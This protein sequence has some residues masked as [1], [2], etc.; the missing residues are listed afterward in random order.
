MR[1]TLAGRQTDRK[2]TFL[3]NHLIQ[4]INMQKFIIS[5][6]GGCLLTQ[7]TTAQNLAGFAYGTPSAPTGQEWQSPEQLSLNKE[8]PHAWFFSFADVQTAR[9][10][11]PE[12]SAYWQ[13]LDGE[14][15][16]HWAPNPS[17]RP[18]DFYKPAFDVSG[19][20]KVEVPM[21]WNVAG[22]QKDGT[23]KYGTP[24]YSNQRVIFK[25]TVAVDDWKGGV[26]REPPKDWPTYKDRNEVGSY[27]RTFTV[28]ESWNGR[29]VYV[30]FDG[31]DSFFYLYI[32]GHYVGFSKNS[33][34]TASF[35]ITPYLVKGENV[36]AAEVYRS[37]DASFLESQDMFRLPGI[38]R[39]VALTSTPKVQ[40]RDVRAIPD[41]DATYTNGLL[42]IATDI[43][44]LDKKTAKNY[45]LT[46]SLY[47]NRLYSDE[48]TPVMNAMKSVPV[49]TLL[50][51]ASTTVTT[52]LQA[53]EVKKWSAEAPY[54][55]TLVGELKNEK[56][57]T[58]ETF[59]TIVG[60][61]KVE[62][63]DTPA[64]QDEFGLAG[65]YFYI[66][67]KTVKLK[68]VN[69]HET[70]PERG[71][72]ITRQQM[73]QEVMLMKRANINHVRNSHYSDDPYWYYLCN[74]YGIY[75]EDEA[76]L[77]SH[78]Y[79][80][81]K[82]SLSHPVEWKAAH[83]ARNA[84]MVHANINNPSIVIWS[85]GNEAGPGKNFNAA[86]DAI[87]KI[88]RSRPVQYERNNDIVDMGSN[89][90]P[91]IAWVKG[92]VTGK[93]DIKYPFH[94]SEY[95]H[96]M[97]NATGNLIDYWNAIES[98][99]YFMG[100][101]IWEWVDHG[102]YN[103][104]ANTGTRYL[105]YGGDF[106][107]KPNDGM[108]CMDG[109]MLPDLTP[110][111]QYYEVKKVYQNVGITPVDMKEGKI[112]IF[113]KNYFE[114]FRDYDFTWSLYKDGV[115]IDGGANLIGPR[116]ALGPREKM[117]YTIPYK[118][119]LLEPGSEYF[120]KVQLTL[121]RDLPWAKIGYP[122]MEEQ[123]LVKAAQQAPAITTVA[124]GNKLKIT[125]AGD[126]SVISGKNFTAKFD[127]R[128]G[129]IYSL[130]YNGQ[131]TI[132]EGKGPKL[133]AFRAP[134]DNDNWAMQKWVANGLHNLRHKVIRSSYTL[135]K[136]GTVLLSYTVESQAPNSATL[137]GGTSGHYTVTEH[138]DK[139]FGANDFRF[140]T[141]QNWIIYKDGSIELAS[142][143]TSNNP[144][145]DLARIG[146]TLEMPSAYKDYTYY[147]RGPVNNYNDRKTG[148]FI[149][150]HKAPVAEQGIM[151]SK[152]QAQGNRE[153]VRWCAVTDA[154]G[155]GL[156]FIAS[157]PMSASAL[158]WSQQE[159]MF[160][161]HPYQLPKSSGTHLHLDA[162]VTGLGGNSCGQ[163]APLEYDRTR[164]TARHFSFL[165]RP[166]SG[167]NEQAQADVSL[168][169]E[170]P[171]L[172]ERDRA[173]K[174]TIT[175]NR[176]GIYY[177]IG[178]GRKQLYKKPFTLT[179][180][181]QVKAWYLSAP[182]LKYTNAFGRIESIPTTVVYASSQEPDE[183]DATQLTDGDP[184]T[185]WHT[186]YSVTLAKFPHWVDFD[187]GTVKLLKGFTYLPRQDSRNGNIKNYRVQV[188]LD[189]KTWGAPVAEGSFANDL[190][191]KKV[192]FK[193]PV[194]AR[195]LRFTALIEQS[196][197][198]YASGAEFTVLAQ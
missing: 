20:A 64:A 85:L 163:G 195:Y 19:W 161:P 39:T 80:Y 173:G 138:T 69:R 151:L 137:N 118:Y 170:E 152:P 133:D 147:G 37:S 176:H 120:V 172:I 131:E 145:L 125:T 43:R 154:A 55:Y 155:N 54:R 25:H 93:Y 171:L 103:Y 116:M 159:L 102:L 197:Q 53:G 97:G 42:N 185:Y 180:S 178:N 86:Y 150:L 110:K 35:D 13:S 194:K 140:T 101:A 11:L 2:G 83:V 89:Q 31:V 156:S 136:D 91:S 57:K 65:R 22:I 5:F 148:Q 59:S 144:A 149:E 198:D 71:H 4:T 82:A 121:K 126:Y 111:G 175:G 166:V 50:K 29:E 66:N 21:C 3:K 74:K 73:E 165:I 41:L 45:T 12:A 130:T 1:L 193:Q 7:L 186:M 192:L 62:I 67:G 104:D 27:R 61:R 100:G 47:A 28:P 106:N 162:M 117:V 36:I 168:A 33:R 107:D 187:A 98:T 15:R 124:K 95:G 30:N 81:G 129:T 88:D 40:V 16:F 38:I 9:R 141:N 158:P 77:E 179:A 58:V 167:H 44:N 132:S 139:P 18:A 190:Q 70:N 128:Q 90:Y 72:A 113:N 23:L 24:I 196:G 109:V 14:W 119:N 10:V 142:A 115:K 164:A 56:G 87:K 127:N 122:Q 76:N 183:G 114:P 79:Y 112:E 32:N 46:Y 189:G 123:L 6:I 177:Q 8:Q 174:V 182:T 153:E 99:N 184:T 146:Y 191:L 96:S 75:L 181:G 49:E 17:E 134:V 34:N 92:A 78:E 160:A 68:G 51:G 63:K 60:F 108:F 52:S 94:I 48:N 143:I 26:M 157:R 169:G 135:R 105:A 188:S 84:E